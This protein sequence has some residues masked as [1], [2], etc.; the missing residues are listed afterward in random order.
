MESE[1]IDT[2]RD[3]DK[4]ERDS[5]DNPRCESGTDGE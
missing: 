3:T 2:S 4:R 5:R 1:R